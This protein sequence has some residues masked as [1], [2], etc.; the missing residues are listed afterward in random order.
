MNH[1]IS[2]GDLAVWIASIVGV[3]AEITDDRER[4]RPQKSEVERLVCDNSKILANTN[5]R[6]QYDLKR[7][8]TET[9]EFMKEHLFLYKTD[10]YVV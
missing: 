6:P 7:G 5:W 2:I 9:V 1:E 3:K 8:L 10:V 4:I